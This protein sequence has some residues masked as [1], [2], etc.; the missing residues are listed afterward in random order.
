MAM[1]II[2]VSVQMRLSLLSIYRRWLLKHA[3]YSRVL[4]M[5]AVVKELELSL[6]AADRYSNNYYA[7]SHRQWCLQQFATEQVLFRYFIRVFIKLIKFCSVASGGVGEK[8][9]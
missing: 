7:W 4:M 8:D 5:S 2:H 1:L 3:D 6:I 9:R